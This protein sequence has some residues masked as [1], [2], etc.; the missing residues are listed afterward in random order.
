MLFP[1]WKPIPAE[2]HNCFA[3]QSD[4]CFREQ[5]QYI[6]SKR[7]IP[8]TSPMLTNSNL[9]TS[10]TSKRTIYNCGA[11]GHYTTDCRQYEESSVD[12]M[13]DEDPEMDQ[14]PNPTI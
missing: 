8:H 13:D 14:I 7:S 9:C 4:Q 5:E 3:M 10:L 2:L 1:V 11:M 6:H 12:Y